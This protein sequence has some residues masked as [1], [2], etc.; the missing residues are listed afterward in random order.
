MGSFTDDEGVVISTVEWA[1]DDPRAVIQISHGIGEHAG[2]YA[3]LAA[4]L[5]RA[6]FT[7]VADDHRGHGATGMAQWG[8]AAKLGSLGPGGLRATIAAI[9]RFRD[10]TKERFPDLPLVLVAHSWGSLMAQIALNGRPDAYDGVVLTGTAYRLPGFM[11]AGDLNRRHRS[12]GTTGAEWLSR[13]PAVAQDWLRDP[14]TFPANTAKL[15]GMRDALRL[16]GRP[17]RR[18]P[19]DL[20]LLLQVGSDDTLGGGRSVH[21]LARAYR[22][23]AGLRDVT[24]R[25]YEG[26]RHEVFNETNRDEVIADL[27]G[28]IE[29]HVLKGIRA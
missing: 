27:V 13:D 4:D 18:L 2:R 10:L 15:I 1:V 28:W 24:V 29:S 14:L 3:A 25:V 5:N 8:D 20:P 23:R 9:G 21:R 22:E 16:L 7:V 26:A 17:G 11:D 6:G 12:L 19:A